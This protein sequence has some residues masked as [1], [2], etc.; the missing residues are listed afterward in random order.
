[1]FSTLSSSFFCH[2]NK[3]DSNEENSSKPYA[4]KHRGESTSNCLKF[5]SVTTDIDCLNQIKFWGRDPKESKSTNK[6]GAL[7]RC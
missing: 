3:K 2:N 1:M 6:A 4:N 5:K 7:Y